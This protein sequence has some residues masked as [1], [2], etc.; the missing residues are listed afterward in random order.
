MGGVI[1]KKKKS[2]LDRIV[3]RTIN[4]PSPNTQTNCYDD[5]CEVSINEDDASALTSRRAELES[6]IHGNSDAMVVFSGKR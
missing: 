2:F 6:S 3:E 5:F 1:A 4:K